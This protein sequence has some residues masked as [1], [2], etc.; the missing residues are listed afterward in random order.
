MPLV[1]PSDLSG[2]SLSF[3]EFIDCETVSI[4]YDQLG[5]ATVSF[6]VIAVLPEPIDT[7]IYTD[8]VFGGIQFTGFITN[9]DVRR[10]SGTIVYEHRYTINGVGCK[11]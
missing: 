4:N 11:V 10:I 8:L 9:L 5:Q 1:C 6:V 3:T 2:V 7:S